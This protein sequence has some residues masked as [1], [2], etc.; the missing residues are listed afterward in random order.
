MYQTG[1]KLHIEN[2]GS[3]EG[4]LQAKLEILQGLKKGATLFLNG[5]NE[6]VDSIKEKYGYSQ[7]NVFFDETKTFINAITE[8]V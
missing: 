8:I 3:R 4:I 6:T 2:L 5:D 1:Y 7:F